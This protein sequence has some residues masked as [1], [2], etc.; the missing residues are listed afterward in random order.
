MQAQERF[1]KNVII[2]MEIKYEIKIWN[3]PG[4]KLEELMFQRVFFSF[5]TQ[6]LDSSICL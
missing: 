4:N 1:D 5:G 6:F 3:S 2:K